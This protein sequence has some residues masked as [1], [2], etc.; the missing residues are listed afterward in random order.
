M[1]SNTTFCSFDTTSGYTAVQILV[2]YFLFYECHPQIALWL[3][4]THMP[5]S[6]LMAAC[7]LYLLF[8]SAE[9][10]ITEKLFYGDTKPVAQFLDRRNCRAI[11]AS[12]DDI[13]DR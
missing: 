12:A 4:K 9:Q 3:Y 1:L 11:I 5:P 7:S 10:F 8:Q 2:F 6:L 13:V